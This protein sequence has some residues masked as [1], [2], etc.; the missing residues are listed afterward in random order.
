MKNN[1]TWR[2]TF[3]EDESSFESF[4]GLTGLKAWQLTLR[5]QGAGSN[6]CT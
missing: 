1:I 2:Y 5:G 6:V 4:G 3:A